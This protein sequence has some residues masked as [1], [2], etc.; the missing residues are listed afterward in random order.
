MRRHPVGRTP[1][2][3]RPRPPGRAPRCRSTSRCPSVCSGARRATAAPCRCSAFAVIVASGT[4]RPRVVAGSAAFVTG[5]PT[6]ATPAPPAPDAWP[7]TARAAP[8]PVVASARKSR[9]TLN[10][11]RRRPRG[12]PRRP[13][14]RPPWPRPCRASGSPPTM[15][16]SIHAATAPGRTPPASRLAPSTAPS[17]LEALA[18]REGA[19]ARGA[20]AAGAWGAT[21]ATT[22]SRDALAGCGTPPPPHLLERIPL[23]RARRRPA[24]GGR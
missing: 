18:L 10:P 5:R 4:A 14:P 20:R 16:R 3:P 15:S 9:I 12:C 1:A 13:H 19:T 2:R 8:G 17:L 6:G 11:P 24:G 23:A 22:P 21:S 7:P